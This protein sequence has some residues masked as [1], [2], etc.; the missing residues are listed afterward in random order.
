MKAGKS[1]VLL[2]TFWLI[3]SCSAEREE[4]PALEFIGLHQ[5][6]SLHGL[7]FDLSGIVEI[8]DSIYV[9]ADKPWNKFLYGIDLE[10]GSFHVTT[11]KNLKFKEKLDLEGIDYCSGMTYLVN[12]RQGLVYR[13]SDTSQME[14]LEI[15]FDS[16]KMDPMNWG[17]AGWEGIAVD[18]GNNTLYLIKERDPRLIIKVDLT[19]LAIKDTFNIPETQSN[20]FSDAKFDNGYLYLIERNGNYITKIDPVEKEVI[21]KYQYRQITSH[22]NGKL[23]GPTEYGM[24]EALLF[25]NDEIWVGL[26]NN[27]LKVTEHAMKTYGMSGKSPVILKFKRP[28]GF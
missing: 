12:E 15:D 5:L 21:A 16:F 7:K 13:F 4:Y 20:D 27:G 11:K 26:D 19:T 18:C 25:I 6:D 24:G 22:K 3:W 28:E 2:V 23:Y 1:I 8:N 9:I 14:V 10:D 17:N